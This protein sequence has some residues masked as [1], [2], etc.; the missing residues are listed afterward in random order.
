MGTPILKYEAGQ[1]AQAF[2]AMSDSGDNTT[3]TATF[4][5]VSSKSGFEPVIAPYG[6]L[7]GAVITPN[8][9]TD[10]GVTVAALT[11]SMAG[12]TGADS[13]GAVSV[14]TADVL[15][16]RGL[17]TDTHRITSI[18]VSSTPAIVAIA[19]IDH[20]EFSETRGAAGGPP[21]I[22]D[23]SIEIGQVRLTSITAGDVTTSEIFQ[24]PGLHLERSDNPVST[25][26]SGNGELTFANALDLIHT[27]SIPKQVWISGH[28]PL[29]SPVP[30]VSDFVPAKP[31]YST[32]STDTY[33]GPVGSS[34]STLG[35]GS[36]TFQAT[37]GITDP[38]VQQEGETLWFEFRPD[39]NASFPKQYTQGVLGIAITN[40]VQ[41]KRPVS[42]TITADAK[43]V[44]VLS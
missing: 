39:R 27:G 38:L 42:C 44:D 37:D 17:T 2:E 32:N 10:E 14:S 11:A 35:Q 8:T 36:F 34:S 5:P 25:L 15:A 21:F 28:T 43:S 16:S 31:S 40:P 12:A 23:G 4:S 33:D 29:F 24:V 7:T 6:L 26:N 3:F 1:V 13:A 18:T 22:P 30:N 20:T 19:G 41:G 9:G